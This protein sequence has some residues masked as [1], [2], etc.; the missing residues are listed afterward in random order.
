VTFNSKEVN[1]DDF[2]LDF[3]KEFGLCWKILGLLFGLLQTPG[4][5]AVF[6]AG[7][8]CFVAFFI[9]DQKANILLKITAIARSPPTPQRKAFSAIFLAE[10]ITKTVGL[11]RGVDLISYFN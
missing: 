3:V 6:F 2:C 5:S 1:Y 10:G 4:L 11:C 7:S 9:T 8:G